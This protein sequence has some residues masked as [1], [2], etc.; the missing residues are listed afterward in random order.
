M[1]RPMDGPRRGRCALLLLAMLQVRSRMKHMMEKTHET[2]DAEACTQN[3]QPSMQRGC[4][5]TAT[6]LRD[7]VMREVFAGFDAVISDRLAAPKPVDID[8]QDDDGDHDDE[9]MNEQR[10][11]VFGAVHRDVL[12][13]SARMSDVRKHHKAGLPFSA[14][15]AKSEAAAPEEKREASYTVRVPASASAAKPTQKFENRPDPTNLFNQQTTPSFQ[16]VMTPKSM[17][18]GMAVIALTCLAMGTFMFADAGFNISIKAQY[19]PGRAAAQRRAA[20]FRDSGCRP[21]PCSATRGADGKGG[22]SVAWQVRGGGDARPPQ[23]VCVAVPRRVLCGQRVQHGD[24]RRGEHHG[25][26]D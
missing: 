26:H 10:G 16:P 19:V 23:C 21:E 13:A 11:D 24:G 25:V 17:A 7:R 6:A 14:E 2:Y 5:L 3:E 4:E 15:A 9:H 22:A 8:V 12:S 20:L 18:R 1:R